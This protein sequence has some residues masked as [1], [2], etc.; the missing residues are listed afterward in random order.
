M[1]LVRA[2]K[3]HT[4]AVSRSAISP[5]LSN[6]TTNILEYCYLMRRRERRTHERTNQNLEIES[7][8]GRMKLWI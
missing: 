5:K 6:E 7:S 1:R 2:D 3:V 8:L 4:R